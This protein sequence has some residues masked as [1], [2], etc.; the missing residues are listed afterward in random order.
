M[1]KFK[2]MGKIDRVVRTVAGAIMF[3]HGMNRKSMLGKLE[4][5]IGGAFLYYGF[6]GRDPLLEMFDASTVP[7]AE[8]NVVKLIKKAV[9]CK[10]DESDSALCDLLP[11]EDKNHKKEKAV[12]R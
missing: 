6:T 7:G 2:N 1:S 10:N 9:P 11:S 3:F 5:T 12:A 4:T 8:N